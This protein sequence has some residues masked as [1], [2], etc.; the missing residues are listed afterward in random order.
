MNTEEINLIPDFAI[1]DTSSHYNKLPTNLLFEKIFHEDEDTKV[2]VQ[3][4]S[5][6]FDFDSLVNATKKQKSSLYTW[7]LFLKYK[8]SLQR[9]DIF[10]QHFFLLKIKT[11]CSKLRITTNNFSKINKAYPS[12]VTRNVMTPLNYEDFFLRFNKINEFLSSNFKP[13]SETYEAP[14]PNLPKSFACLQWYRNDVTVGQATLIWAVVSGNQMDC[15]TKMVS[16]N[17]LL[18][19]SRGVNLLKQ[20]GI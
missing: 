7:L 12:D 19:M 1:M 16:T 18:E 9:F 13:Y 14:S 2:T 8:T 4:K 11:F 10:P 17:Q 3:M 20:V 15:G 6:E 5:D